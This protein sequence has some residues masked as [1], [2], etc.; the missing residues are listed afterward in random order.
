MKPL[1]FPVR[2]AAGLVVVAVERVC[3]LPRLVVEL[4]VTA[5]S[6]ALQAPMQVQQKLTELAIKGDR[7]LGMLR[8]VEEKPSWA[9]VDQDEPRSRNGASSITELHP[10]T[11]PPGELRVDSPE[12]AV[13]LND[14]PANVPEA[15]DVPAESVTDEL[16]AEEVIAEATAKRVDPSGLP[17]L[18]VLG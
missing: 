16:A 12:A 11:V 7:L 6:Q 2:I 10:T 14:L 15:G 1:P 18:V 9:T 13:V 4:P 8:P 3:D 17:V 5:V